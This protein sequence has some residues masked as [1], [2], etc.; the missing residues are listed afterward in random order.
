[1]EKKLAMAV[2][3]A[4]IETLA[5]V[6][7]GL[8]PEGHLYMAMQHLGIDLDGYQRLV[9]V[10]VGSGLVEKVPGP[11]LRITTKGR[12]LADKMTKIRAEKA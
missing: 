2:I 8:A 12:E 1:M 9:G 5:E 10:M 7:E 11:Q 6:P 4:T 3:G